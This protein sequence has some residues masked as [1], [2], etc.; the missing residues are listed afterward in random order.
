MI[1]LKGQ[2]NEAVIYTDH[3]EN[4]AISQIFSLLN[5]KALQ[6]TRIRIMPDVHA[7]AGIPIGTSIQLLG[8][9]KDWKVA[10]D[11]VSGDIHC[12]MTTV[13]LKESQLDLHRLEEAARR[14]IPTGMNYH[15]KP[16]R[17]DLVENLINQLSFKLDEKRSL[18]AQQAFGTLGGG[19]HFMELS[20]DQHGVLWLTIH[21]GS[22]NFG[23]S[24][25]RH[26]RKIAADN[27][28]LRQQDRQQLKQEIERLKQA[29]RHR[30][31][32]EFLKN[33]KRTADTDTIFPYLSGQEL[34]N[35]IQDLEL[36]YQYA[37]AS[38]L[39]IL[40]T[41]V[42]SLKL[43][44]VYTFT[45]PHNYFDAEKG[46]I[47]KGATNAAKDERV[48]IPI[49][50]RDGIYIGVGLGN[51]DWNESAPHGAGRVYSRSKA[52]EVISLEDFK[53][54]MEGIFSTNITQSNV[55]ESPFAYKSSDDIIPHL[56]DSVKITHHL[57]P[58]WSFKA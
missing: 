55:D 32:E 37:Q 15:Q 29:G 26:H 47:R 2:Y 22:R 24:I 25:H 50:M 19:N 33:F 52:K 1:T 36:A 13:Q 23:S 51:Q 34:D 38:R 3:V 49:N 11:I 7:G 48:L 43:N 16:V 46:I 27:S 20:K 42:K 21:T 8:D 9:R 35:Y 56:T 45:S 58:L 28:K 12:S 14:L 53:E 41:L 18:M 57:K 39:W 4:E 6:N 54:S 17:Y 5:D 10:P 44:T 30:E 40:Q 31:I